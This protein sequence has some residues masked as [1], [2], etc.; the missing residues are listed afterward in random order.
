M[1][2]AFLLAANTFYGNAPLWPISLFIGLAI[3][4]AAVVNSADL[5]QRWESE[6]VDYPDDIRTDLRMAAGGLMLAVLAM[7]L[8]I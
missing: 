8:V 3:L 4:L 1:V 2:M 7:S 5:E 6:G